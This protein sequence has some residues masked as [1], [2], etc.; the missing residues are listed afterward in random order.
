MYMGII[1]DGLGYIAA[2]FFTMIWSPCSRIELRRILTLENEDERQLTSPSV[3]PTLFVFLSAAAI[4]S[5]P[6]KV[7]M[8]A[9]RV[10]S[11]LKNAGSGR[12][13]ASYCGLELF[14]VLGAYVVKLGL[15]LGCFVVKSG[16]GSGLRA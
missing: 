7:L 16:L 15:G 14:A 12:A 4:L 1:I 5:F 10:G 3:F 6:L 8:S 13:R 2:D 9:N 11:G